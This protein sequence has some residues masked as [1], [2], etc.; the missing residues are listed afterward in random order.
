MEVWKRLL[1]R[2]GDQKG[3]L[4]LLGHTGSIATPRELVD[5]G[6][7]GA[8][9]VT[10]KHADERKREGKLQPVKAVAF[11]APFCAGGEL[12]GG[13]PTPGPNF[14][15]FG[16]RTALELLRQILVA[17]EHAHLLGVA[18]MDLKPEQILL[19]KKVEPDTD[20]ADIRGVVKLTDWGSAQQFN[21]RRPARTEIVAPAKLNGYTP[22]YLP[23]D[24]YNSQ[25][26][27]A[28]VGKY[29][30]DPRKCDIY[31]AGITLAR[32]CGLKVVN[33]GMASPNLA[34]ENI[35]LIFGQQIDA[36]VRPVCS[37]LLVLAVCHAFALRHSFFDFLSG[38]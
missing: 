30:L 17:L 38:T 24:C 34:T 18:H 2:G 35:G 28:R 22:M 29:T 32:I 33:P 23:P 19:T 9:K 13:Q 12:P 5:T 20:P 7:C 26:Q 27:I 8:S 31:A 10:P 37:A 14:T 36:T 21:T 6:F 3:I 1:T 25:V 15:P 11:I 16:A 4:Q